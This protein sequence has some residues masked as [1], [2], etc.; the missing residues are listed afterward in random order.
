MIS[1]AFLYLI[2]KSQISLVLDDLKLYFQ[3]KEISVCNISVTSFVNLYLI[4]L[5]SSCA[6]FHQILFHMINLFFLIL[7]LF[8][9]ILYIPNYFLII[10]FVIKSQFKFYFFGLFPLTFFIK[11]LTSLIFFILLVLTI[12]EIKNDEKIWYYHSHQ[13]YDLIYYYREFWH[14]VKPS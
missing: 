9:P 11:P 14:K 5:Y 2:G 13:F 7:H 3:L 1:I 8:H 12:L 10:K 4:F 6:N